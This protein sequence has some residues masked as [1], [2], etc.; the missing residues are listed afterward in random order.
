MTNRFRFSVLSAENAESGTPDRALQETNCHNCH[1]RSY[2]LRR[3]L[4][5]PKGTLF[6]TRCGSLTTV[7]SIKKQRGLAA[8]TIQQS[9]AHTG[10][11]QQHLTTEQKTEARTP[12]SLL[13]RRIKNPVIES[14]LKRTGIQLLDSNTDDPTVYE[15]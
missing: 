5:D 11:A 10:I 7:R 8:P 4:V 3:E 12:Q 6:C 14:L 13:H 9:A 2:L 15:A 1:E